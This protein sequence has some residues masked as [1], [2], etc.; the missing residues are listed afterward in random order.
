MLACITPWRRGPYARGCAAPALLCRR[1]SAAGTSH[2]WTRSPSHRSPGLPSVRVVLVRHRGLPGATAAAMLQWAD[3]GSVGCATATQSNP[4]LA[5]IPP[6]RA[7]SAT[8]HSA[9]IVDALRGARAV[10]RARRALARRGH[11]TRTLSL[12]F[13]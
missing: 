5:I 9:P 6:V 7:T 12:S 10:P 8:T 13:S 11:P 4:S 3:D 2:H 1:L